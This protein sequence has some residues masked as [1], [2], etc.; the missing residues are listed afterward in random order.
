MLFSNVN[1]NVTK[2]V[3]QKMLIKMSD[4]FKLAK[5]RADS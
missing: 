4:V 1:V 3:Q 2:C 5:T